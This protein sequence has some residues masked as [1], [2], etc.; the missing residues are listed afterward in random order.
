[1]TAKQKRGKR[2]QVVSEPTYPLR[3]H[4]GSVV[5][6]GDKR[7]L[8]PN[9]DQG[10]NRRGAGRNFSAL[11]SGVMLLFLIACSGEGPDQDPS[12]LPSHKTS[13]PTILR[14]IIQWPGDDFASKQDLETRSKIESLI[15]ERSVGKILRDGTGMGWMDIF[16][17]A[18]AG[19]SAKKAIHE[20]MGEA[21]PKARY[22]IE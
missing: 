5:N 11:L 18:K 1:M 10:N 4:A 22:L 6:Q 21:A 3:S 16:V 20:I 19:E 8:Q 15:E 14:I 2:L 13:M 7:M 12:L 9:G 17:E